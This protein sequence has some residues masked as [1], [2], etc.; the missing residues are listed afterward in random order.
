[1]YSLI[2]KGI[3][4]VQPIYIYDMIL[5]N[6]MYSNGLNYYIKLCVDA[7]LFV[8]IATFTMSLHCCLNHKML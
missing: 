6:L 5:C 3:H 8:Y 4:N 7:N 1:M 2:L